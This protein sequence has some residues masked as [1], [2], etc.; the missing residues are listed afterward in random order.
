MKTTVAEFN[1]KEVQRKHAIGRAAAKLFHEKGYLETS[2][3]DISSEANLSKGCIYYYFS[4]KHEILY[5]ILD[6]Y[7]NHLMDG[8][9]EELKD[10]K[11]PYLKI[12]YIMSRHLAL[13]NNKVPEAKAILID[14]H[15]LPSG[16]YREIAAK[17]KK[18]AQVLAD[19]LS[20]FFNGKKPMMK[21]KAIS[22][23]LF[24]MCNSIMHWHNPDGPI[25]LEE[26]SDICFD[27][28]LNGVNC[29]KSDKSNVHQDTV[30]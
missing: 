20:E 25:K 23:I 19:V 9:E 10:I 2:L 21:L 30:L 17:Q 11:D 26:L 27:I 14:A 15:N 12:K 5:F 1:D 3:K 8:L 22:Y 6:T 16:Y 4:N 24:G 13:Y 28:F 18:Y 7:M 29:Y